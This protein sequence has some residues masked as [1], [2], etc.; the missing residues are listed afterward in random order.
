MQYLCVNVF[1]FGW[2]RWNAKQ[3]SSDDAECNAQATKQNILLLCIVFS[4]EK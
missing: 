2:L 4:T 3:I 1:Y